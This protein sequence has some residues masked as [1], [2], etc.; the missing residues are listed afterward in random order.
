M[1]ERTCVGRWVWVMAVGCAV[2]T[3]AWAAGEGEGGSRV[4][5]GPFSPREGALHKHSKPLSDLIGIGW[6]G[7]GLALDP[8]HWGR[9]L[10]GMSQE[11][12]VEEFTTSLVKGG[13]PEKIAK[14]VALR[15]ARNVQSVWELPFERLQF[16]VGAASAGS[17]SNS[18]RRYNRFTG[19]E[20]AVT[21]EEYADGYHIFVHERQTPGRMIDV[22]SEG[23]GGFRLALLRTDASMAIVIDQSAEGCV[24]REIREGKVLSL[25]AANFSEIY[26]AHHAYVDEVLVPVL[27][28]L[29]VS[30][31]PMPLSKKVRAVVLSRL[32]GD[33]DEG[34]RATVEKLVR[35]LDSQA[36]AERMAATEKLSTNYGRYAEVI[37]G[38]L[39]EIDAGRGPQ[40]SPEALVRLR[41]I[42]EDNSQGDRT[43]RAVK[44][45]DLLNDVD[46]L[47]DLL[48]VCK[49]DDRAV[50]V[51]RLS[52]LTGESYGD[53]VDAWR[54][55]LKKRG[56]SSAEGD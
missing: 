23:K 28:E 21:F 52:K 37:A 19:H 3:T 11:E 30:M 16:K 25:K 17:G 10:E 51:N 53:N 7:K 42:V 44:A 4:F 8:A 34:E 6:R 41:K 49:G 26:R 14:R 40:L 50:V 56:E 1:S 31:P 48:A 24:V 12:I 36:Y 54:S 15:R 39:A 27:E 20:L 18:G 46:Y 33:V 32:R 35:Q 45:M 13:V 38:V 9:S 2:G 22:V 5:F 43:G 29:G 47:V 55:W